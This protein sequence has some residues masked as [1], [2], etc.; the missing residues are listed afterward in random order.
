M[1]ALDR[2]S[3][4]EGHLLHHT[5]PMALKFFGEELALHQMSLQE[6]HLWHHALTKPMALKSFGEKLALHQMSLQEGHLPHCMLNN[7]NYII[8][9][10]AHTAPDVPPG[11]TSVA[12]CITHG[13][14]VFW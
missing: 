4:L 10:N 9:G 7:G 1:L 12:S 6:G 3:L 5:L 14:Q 11:G 8:L 13:S 2:M